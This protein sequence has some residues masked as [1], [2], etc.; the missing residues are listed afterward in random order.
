MAEA[1]NTDKNVD[2][3]IVIPVYNEAGAI[4]DV[5]AELRQVLDSWPETWEI[6]VVDDGST[7]DTVAE[8]AD[9][10]R[11]IKCPVN[12]GY[13]ASLKRG[14]TAARGEWLVML[15]GDGS[16]PVKQL[17]EMKQWIPEWDQICG[18]RTTEAGTWKPVRFLAKWCIRKLSEIVS[19]KKI[20]DL[21]SGIRM[22]RTDLARSFLW[23]FPQRFSASTTLTLA[24]LCNGHPIKFVDV[25]YAPRVGQSNF[26]PVHDTLRFGMTV[27]RVVLYFN[28]LRVLFPVALAVSMV[29]ILKS[30][31]DIVTFPTGVHD[32]DII[33]ITTGVLLAV[34]ALLADLIV[35]VAKRHSSIDSS[36]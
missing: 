32:T 35:S 19:G 18:V 30:I 26:R 7:D 16:Y 23:A 33:L 9:A 3:S 13:G 22:I 21:N 31:Y 29:G 17:N 20:P 12:C 1:S 8:A 36:K 11:V 34:L 24:F 14:F 6:V 5:I 15:D 25:D 27:I 2:F 28:P 10:T 4:R